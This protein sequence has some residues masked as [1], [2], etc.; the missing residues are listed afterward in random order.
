MPYVT[1]PMLSE[2]NVALRRREEISAQHNFMRDSAVDALLKHRHPE[3][4]EKLAQGLPEGTE[5]SKAEQTIVANAK[6]DILSA[7]KNPS[8]LLSKVPDH[9]RK[10]VQNYV[11][12][13]KKHSVLEEKL[14]G[15][16]T[17]VKKHFGADDISHT[18]DGIRLHLP[19]GEVTIL[20]EDLTPRKLQQYAKQTLLEESPWAKA[21]NS[22]GTRAAII[23]GVV[24]LGALGAYGALHAELEKRRNQR[25]MGIQV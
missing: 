19:K 3:L 12:A 10:I 25:E 23:G 14:A 15:F 11:E 6:A 20:S 21:E 17:V 5:L 18:P 7:T 9:V 22:K 24:L 4:A 1:A 2:Y 16:E 13:H 8:Q